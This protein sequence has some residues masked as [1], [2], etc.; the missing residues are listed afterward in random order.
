MNCSVKVESRV[1]LALLKSNECSHRAV[2]R[3]QRP[4]P[5]DAPVT[6]ATFVMFAIT[7][8]G[9]LK[10]RSVPYYSLLFNVRI[11]QQ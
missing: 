7:F 9:K 2:C 5:D 10:Q 1:G 6:N 11:E 4:M 8:R 3:T